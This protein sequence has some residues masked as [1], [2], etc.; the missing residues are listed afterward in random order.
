MYLASFRRI[1]VCRRLFLNA[2]VD[3]CGRDIQVDATRSVIY[4]QIVATPPKFNVRRRLWRHFQRRRSSQSGCRRYGQRTASEYSHPA[5][6]RQ[7]A[8]CSPN[9]PPEIVP[10]VLIVTALVSA[11]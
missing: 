10:S 9:S 7:C 4:G 5:R 2:A 3:D 6:H 11:I 8:D 1:E